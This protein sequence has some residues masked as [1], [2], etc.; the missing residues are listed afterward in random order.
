MRI[1][2]ILLTSFLLG[3]FSVTYCQAHEDNLADQI[4]IEEAAETNVYIDEF[5]E[6]SDQ[7][8]QYSN[9]QVAPRNYVP[10]TD[11]TAAVLETL[12]FRPLGLV[13]TICGT[14]LFAGMSPLTALAS[15][16]PPHDAFLKTADAL[17][18][19]PAEYTFTRPLGDFGYS[20]R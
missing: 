4:E 3:L 16:A 18:V 13:T 15:I 11:G 6:E 9:Y 19:S 20:N 8:Q 1:V 2:K 12:F 14:A 5:A 7:D 10:N 17:I